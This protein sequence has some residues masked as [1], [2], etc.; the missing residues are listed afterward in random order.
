M[1]GQAVSEKTSKLKKIILEKYPSI[2][3]FA[4][5]SGIPHGTIVSAL[6]NGVEGMAWSKVITICDCL[7]IDYVTF[8]PI[9]P[10][11]LDESQKRLLAYFGLLDERKKNKVIE[12]IMD[13]R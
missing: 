6:N 1:Q 9:V 11:S 8:E 4:R 12:Y 10:S 3:E 7:E 13:I 5:Q 2:R